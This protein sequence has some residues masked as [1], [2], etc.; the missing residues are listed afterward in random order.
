MP[1]DDYGNEL[2]NTDGT[3]WV[4]NT[5]T[6]AAEQDQPSYIQPDIWT[7]GAEVGSWFAE[8]LAAFVR[9]N[10]YS[11]EPEQTGGGDFGPRASEADS[12][13][14]KA[15]KT[16]DNWFSKLFDTVG[17]AIGWDSM[18]DKTKGAVITAG[19]SLIAGAGAGYAASQKAALDK[20]M[21]DD[22]IALE[23]QKRDNQAGIINMKFGQPSKGRGLLFNPAVQHARKVI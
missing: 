5:D 4:P 7:N 12:L 9:G 2:T 15:V 6:P 19:A 3:P 8:G 21:A 17:K 20:Q 18:G 1:L 14:D 22:K 23:K 11:R 16:S 10:S 13:S